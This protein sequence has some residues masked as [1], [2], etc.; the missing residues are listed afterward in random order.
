MARSRDVEVCAYD[1]EGLSVTGGKL[2][3]RLISRSDFLLER[4]VDVTVRISRFDRMSGAVVND[5]PLHS[6]G[7]RFKFV[8]EVK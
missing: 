8:G 1:V 4:S 2:S 5:S 7:R 3:H 6:S